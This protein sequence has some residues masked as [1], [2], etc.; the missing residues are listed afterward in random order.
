MYNS[1][2][3][4]WDSENDWGIRPATNPEKPVDEKRSVE[5]EAGYT[6][7]TIS[8]LPFLIYH[9]VNII[10]NL[11]WERMD[12]L[13]YHSTFLAINGLAVS[14]FVLQSAEERGRRGT[15]RWRSKIR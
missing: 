15:A 9:G 10:E 2:M 14:Y 7:A 6:L 3:F 1:P 8:A 11:S 12:R 13:I 4:D 5:D